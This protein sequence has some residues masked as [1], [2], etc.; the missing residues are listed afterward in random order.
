MQVQGSLRRVGEPV[1]ANHAS[2]G[3][4][5]QNV[6]HLTCHF[7]FDRFTEAAASLCDFTARSCRRMA[8]SGEEHRRLIKGH[9]GDPPFSV[10]KSQSSARTLTATFLA[11]ALSSPDLCG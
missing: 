2:Y 5:M 6:R 1:V 11:L 8:R 7:D 4:Q 10:A 9:G 3:K